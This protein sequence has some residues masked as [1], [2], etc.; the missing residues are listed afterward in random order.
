MDGKINVGMTLSQRYIRPAQQQTVYMM[1]QLRQPKIDLG[2]ERLPLNVSFVL[3]RSGSMHGAKLAYTKRAVNFAL[4]HLDGGDIASVVTF[5]SEVDVLLPAEKVTQKDA[6]VQRVNGLYPGG[7]TNL[8]GGLLRGAGLVRENV[9]DGLVN[10]VVLL[11]D[12]LANEGITAPDRLVSM[13]KGLREKQITVSTLGVGSD[14]QEDLLVEMAE[15]G[16]GNFYFIESPDKIPEIFRDELQGLLSVTGQNLEL[17]VT[18]VEHVAV[19]GILGYEPAWGPEV[20]IKLPDMYNGDVKTVLVELQVR[21]EAEGMM[22]LCR[23]SFKYDDVAGDL[24]AVKYDIDV[25][26]DVTEDEE[27]LNAGYSM[28]VVK[29]VEIFKTAQV[30]E[31]AIKKADSGDFTVAARMI[32]LQEE[33]LQAI[34]AETQDEDVLEEMERLQESGVMMA[35]NVFDP[36]ARKTMKAQSY[37]SRK[38]R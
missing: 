8:S 35:E 32:K 25:T 29:E 10:R 34:F 26:A 18:P 3:D 33:K 23:V 14:F 12:G 30:K 2:E 22:P 36:M 24:A 31:E 13:V 38:K 5:D 17:S 37:R 7:T 19:T 16:N 27:Q 4:E 9:A 15:A 1:V 20:K 6:M 21:P 11:T 28:D